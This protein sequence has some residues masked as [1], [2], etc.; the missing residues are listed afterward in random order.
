MSTK[1]REIEG[2]WEEIAARAA[3]FAGHRVRLTVFPNEE[4]ETQREE[5]K[6]RML[7]AIEEMQ[8]TP[9]TEEEKAILDDFERFRKEHP[10][11][12]SRRKAP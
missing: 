11:S 7:A 10:F 5:R 3:E 6:R 2:T 4:D 8:R 9:L 12:L 1:T